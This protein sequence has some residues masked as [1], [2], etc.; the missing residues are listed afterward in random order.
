MRKVEKIPS[1]GQLRGAARPRDVTAQECSGI[2][3]SWVHAITS[4][5]A[6]HC[7]PEARAE[8]I[9]VAIVIPLGSSETGSDLVIGLLCVHV[10]R[11]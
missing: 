3:S 11:A 6:S 8:I 2:R 10:G 5:L 4:L 7:L 9:L 1:G